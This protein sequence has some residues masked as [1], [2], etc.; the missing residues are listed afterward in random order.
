MIRVIATVVIPK[1]V[2]QKWRDSLRPDRNRVEL[3]LTESI[4]FF[5]AV[6]FCSL[7]SKVKVVCSIVVV[8]VGIN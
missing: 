8:V 2:R 1:G 5:L 7:L 4:P 6:F 3:L